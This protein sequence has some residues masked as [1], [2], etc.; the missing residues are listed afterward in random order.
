MEYDITDDMM[1]VSY[2]DAATLPRL[3]RNNAGGGVFAV[4]DWTRLRRFLCL[5][6]ENSIY[7]AQKTQAFA[8]TN[9]A[10]ILRLMQQ[11]HGVQVVEVIKEFSLAGRAAKQEPT[12]YALAACARRGDTATRSAAYHAVAQVCRIPTHLFTFVQFCEHMVPNSTGWGR[13]MRRAIGLWYVAKNPY[14]LA[15]LATKY[16]T[17]VDWSHRDLL[18]LAHCAPVSSKRDEDGTVKIE[19]D[20][21]SASRQL[22]LRYLVKGA[23]S[24]KDA[25]QAFHA[26]LAIAGADVAEFQRT[27]EFLTTFETLSGMTDA[28]RLDEDAVILA[29]RRFHLAREHLPTSSLNSVQVWSALLVDMPLQALCRS[30]NKMT[31]LGLFEDKD[32]VAL[33]VNKLNSDKAI[34]AARLHPFNILVAL[35]T[36]AS[37]HGDKGSLVWRP[38]QPIVAALEGAFYKSFTAVQPT[39]QRCCIALDVS[40]SMSTPVHG[41]NVIS[42]REASV[43]LAMVTARTEPACHM[44]CFTTTLVPLNTYGIDLTKDSL[45]SAVSN[46]SS[47][48]FGGTDCAQPM[49]WATKNKV[50][51]DTFIVF[52]DSETWA[53]HVSPKS[54]LKTYRDK[55]KIPHARLIV[56]GLASNGFSIADPEDPGMLDVAGFDANG[57]QV[58]RSFMLGEI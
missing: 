19:Y 10:A 8:L 50:D 53:G 56:V 35:R 45:D 28:T 46:S 38:V 36:Y 2:A 42:C 37:G 44:L 33:V 24:L 47:I 5:G 3:V 11:G 4:D 27:L 22:V 30:L 32:K 41:S 52:T 26:D 1:D 40:G 58:M 7:T 31:A 34:H 6:V 39:G 54:A 17:R 25:E 9:E 23:D 20:A 18:R 48:S 51:V 29:A 21:H 57:P 14:G 43:A 15:F 49:I 12:L 55:A 16:R 13:G